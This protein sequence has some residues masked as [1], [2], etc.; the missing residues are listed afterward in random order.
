MLNTLDIALAR[1]PIFDRGDQLV[2]YELLYRQR[3][4]DETAAAPATVSAARMTSD[5]ITRT[6]LGMGLARVTAGKL[7]FV[8]VDR[9]MLMGHGL[10]VLDPSQVVL[11]ILETVECDAETVAACEALA[12]R[13]FTLALDDFLPDAA[14]EPFLLLAR[15]VKLDVLDRSD[16][17]LRATLEYLRPFGVQCLAE[18]V[19][20]QAVHRR[21][22]TLGFTL[23]QGYFYARPEVLAGREVPVEQANVIRLLNVLRDPNTSDTCVEAI[24][25]A[26]LPLTY[27]L[28]RIV[29]AAGSGRSGIESIGHAIRLVGRAALHRWLALLL[30]SS[31]ASASGVRAERVTTALVRARFCEYLAEAMGRDAQRG[32]LFMVGLFSLLDA[33]MQVPMADALARLDLSDDLRTALLDRRGQYAETLALT[34]QYEA[35]RWDEVAGTS[36]ALGIPLDRIAESY[37][38]AVEWSGAHMGAEAGAS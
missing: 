20:T 4:S 9:E 35:G 28:L 38:L 15:I 18:R 33:L 36:A 23:F 12:A 34:E 5:T 19:E 26:D 13:G 30:V 37:A 16:A 1:Q 25:R 24:F 7:A 3:A 11:E 10:G 21:C 14:R 6:F 31:F 32:A 27:Q 2:A 29:N 22:L 8:N 17:D